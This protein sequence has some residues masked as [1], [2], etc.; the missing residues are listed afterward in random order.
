ML[1][2]HQMQN[3]QV[4]ER[5]NRLEQELKQI[6]ELLKKSVISYGSRAWWEKE[7]A[8]ADEAIKRGKLHKASSVREL[9]KQLER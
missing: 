5:I 7:E 3:Q 4:L 2:W 9:I 8:E 6:K 1:D